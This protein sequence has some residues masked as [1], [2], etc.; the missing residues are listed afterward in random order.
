MPNYMH[1]QYHR[2]SV[3]ALAFDLQSGNLISAA[4]DKTVACWSIYKKEGEAY[5]FIHS[6]RLEKAEVTN[7]FK[8]CCGVSVQTLM[9]LADRVG[10][11]PLRRFKTITIAAAFDL[12]N[13]PASPLHTFGCREFSR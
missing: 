9:T 5:S 6:S 13:F 3:A 8:H 11:I 2:S 12:Q 1:L 10:Y 7:P 4:R